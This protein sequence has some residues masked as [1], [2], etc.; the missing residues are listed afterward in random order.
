MINLPG[1]T[2]K[3]YPFQKMVKVHDILYADGPI[4]SHYQLGEKDILY[5]WID[6]NDHSNRWLSWETSKKDLYNY[7]SGG[8]SLFEYLMALETPYVFCTDINLKGEVTETTMLD[9]FAIPE[10]YLPNENSY[11][12]LGLPSFY[13]SYLMTYSYLN[14]LK[15]RSYVFKLSSTDKVHEDTVSAK[16]AGIFL[17]NI[18]KSIENY[19]DATATT[20]LLNEIGD[21]LKLNKII[22]QLKNRIS[23]R[24]TELRYG[25]FEVTMAIDTVVANIEYQ[26]LNEW[27]N[28]VIEGFKNDVLDVDFSNPDDAKA[29][30][31]RFPDP[32]TRKRIYEPFIKILNN[33]SLAITVSSYNKDFKRDY[34]KNKPKEV[35]VESI[36]PQQTIDEVLAQQ[37]KKEK[38]ISAVFKIPEDGKISDFKKKELFENLLFS[39][40]VS[41]IKFP[42]PSPIIHGENV[43]VLKESL[44][45]KIQLSN[46]KVILSHEILDIYAEDEMGKAIEIAKEQFVNLVLTHLQ[47]PNYVDE[48]TQ[49]LDRILESTI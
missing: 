13:E 2:L 15:E 48:K 24:I 8:I 14:K 19:I 27:K 11:Y 32:T 47:N 28:N 31:D 39:E 38:I 5:Y 18:T 43:I 44:N 36:M 45:C 3:T 25:S 17:S 37:E 49:E 42:I 9:S 26:S 33:D 23:P 35:F 20:A 40:E 7:L 6:Y 22:N 16:E 21:R 30:I 4:L 46:D 41:D 29:I 1:Y 10:D 12:S 34:E